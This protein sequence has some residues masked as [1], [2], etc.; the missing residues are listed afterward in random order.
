[1]AT[2][3]WWDFTVTQNLAWFALQTGATEELVQAAILQFDL[4]PLLHIRADYLELADRE[5]VDRAVLWLTRS[6]RQTPRLRLV[7]PVRGGR[8]ARAAGQ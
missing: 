3:L 1:M 7:P 8:S 2:Q 5:R 4:R 6:A